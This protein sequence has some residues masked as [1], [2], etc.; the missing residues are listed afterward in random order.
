LIKRGI[1]DQRGGFVDQHG[2][3]DKRGCFF[4]LRGGF[5]DQRGGFFDQDPHH[6]VVLS[7]NVWLSPSKPEQKK[8]PLANLLS[9]FYISLTLL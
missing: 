4:D 5:F 2:L 1:F 3:F 6:Q 7:L 8:Y 9:Y